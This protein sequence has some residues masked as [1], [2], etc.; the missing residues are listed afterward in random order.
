MTLKWQQPTK[1]INDGSKKQLGTVFY[2]WV[3]DR[4]NRFFNWNNT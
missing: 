3:G 2:N 4:Y 1:N